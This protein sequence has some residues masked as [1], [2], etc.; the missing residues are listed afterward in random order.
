[1][2]T[3]ATKGTAFDFAKNTAPLTFPDGSRALSMNTKRDYIVS[4]SGTSKDESWWTLQDATS[5][6]TGIQAASSES[7][8]HQQKPRK[9]VRDGRLVIEANGKQYSLVGTRIK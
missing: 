7:A 3:D 6:V 5:I 8:P 9:V 4:T 2:I 1:M